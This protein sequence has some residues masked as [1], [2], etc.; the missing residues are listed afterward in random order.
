MK[1]ARRQTSA[2]HSL[3]APPN[4]R[5]NVEAYYHEIAPFYDAELADRD[6]IDFWREI[7]ADHRGGRTL[8]LD[9][10]TGRITVELARYARELIAIDLST[11]L[12]ELARTRLGSRDSV[13]LLR[14]DMRDLVLRE[15]LDL[16]VAA[17]DPF[18]H[19]VRGDERDR[20]LRV[21]AR[22]LAP[23]GRFVLDA[24]WLRP[25][26]ALAIASDGGRVRRH[27][28]SIGGGQVGIVERWERQSGRPHRCHAQYEYRREDSPPVIAGFEARDWSVSEL[29]DRFARA[30]LRITQVWGSYQREAWDADRSTQLIVEAT[31]A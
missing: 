23:G 2:G 28:A 8:E 13:H 18:S 1:R 4:S 29:F 5:A 31:L 30:G 10:G 25:A 22:H 16:I 20:T 17:N 3:D 24:L 7:A 9:A 6:D 12:L 27:A 26:D 11:D 19:L 15:R 14:A 21:V